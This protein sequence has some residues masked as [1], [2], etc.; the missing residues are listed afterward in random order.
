LTT[1]PTL[2]MRTGDFTELNCPNSST[3]CYGTGFTGEG[4]NNPQ[5]IYDPTTATCVGTTCLRQPFM[6]L[7]NGVPTYNVIPQGEISP[8][9]QKMESY[10]PQPTT[11][12]IQNNYLGGTPS[13]YDNWLYSGRIDHQRDGDG[14]QSSCGSL[15]LDFD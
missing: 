6:G 9:A 7:K 2:L 8:I 12:A 3:G 4:S 1:V 5:I 14:R 13:G 11:Q 15:H 10:L